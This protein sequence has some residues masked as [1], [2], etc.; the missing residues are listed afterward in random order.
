MNT[1]PSPYG[2]GSTFRF[3]ALASLTGVLMVVGCGPASPPKGHSGSSSAQA[4]HAH[5]SEGP[6]GGHLIELGDEQY[7]VEL[8]HDDKAGEVTFYILDSSAKKAVPIDAVE[9]VVNLKHGGKA[10]QFK[11]AAKPESGET[12]GTSSR[13]FSADKELAGDLDAEGA[14]AQLVVTI[15]GKQFRGAIE[16]EHGKE[17]DAEHKH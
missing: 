16:H 6:H 14:D 11:I 2:F 12:A 13:F 7:H 10:E 15:S 3:L 5:P 17:G 8:I 4:E 1:N 9:L